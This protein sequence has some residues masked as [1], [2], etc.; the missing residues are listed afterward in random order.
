MRPDKIKLRVEDKFNSEQKAQIA[1]Q[2]AHSVADLET[3]IG[4]KKV[5]DAAFNERIKTTDNKIAELAKRYNKGCEG[6]EIECRIMYDVPRVGKKSYF[7]TDTEKLIEVRDMSPDEKQETLQFPLTTSK[8]TQS[9][10]DDEHPADVELREISFRYV[11]DIA[12]TIVTLPAN[13]RKKA[14]SEM[15]ERISRVIMTQ[16]KIAD[17]DGKVVKVKTLKDA[18]KLA[19]RWLDGCVLMAEDEGSEQITRLCDKTQGC[20]HFADHDGE[21]EVRVPQEPSASS[22]A[23][24]A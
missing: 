14:I 10:D 20:T 7:R 18:D 13:E 19:R 1:E 4:E 24:S 6:K 5:S 9:S 23:A 3:I 21:C 22:D 11:Q 12:A 17:R 2:L 15:P 8:K 16:G